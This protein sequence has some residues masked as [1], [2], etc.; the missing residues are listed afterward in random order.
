MTNIYFTNVEI[1]MAYLRYSPAHSL[2]D[3]TR[4]SQ[5]QLHNAKSQIIM[6]FP[7]C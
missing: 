2:T 3:P 5:S 1:T 7:F 4:L 6:F